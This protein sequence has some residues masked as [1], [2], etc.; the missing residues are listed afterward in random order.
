[1]AN[2]LYH[3]PNIGGA[4]KSKRLS[5]AMNIARKEE[6]RS[7]FK[8]LTNKPTGKGPLG[9]PRHRWEDNVEMYLKE[10]DVDTRNMNYSA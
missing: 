6:D 1:M 8:I 7:A 9:W 5:W 4:I 10:I 3:S 2:I